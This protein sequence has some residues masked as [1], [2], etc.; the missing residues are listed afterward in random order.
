MC[1]KFIIFTIIMAR[2]IDMIYGW[3]EKVRCL[4]LLRV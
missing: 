4:T 3:N 2:V 1:N